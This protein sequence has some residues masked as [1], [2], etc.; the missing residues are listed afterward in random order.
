M[1]IPDGPLAKSGHAGGPPAK[2]LKE[3]EKGLAAMQVDK[4]NEAQQHLKKAQELAPKNP[5]VNYLVGVLYMRRGKS[6]EARDYL[7][8]SRGCGAESRVGFARAGRSRDDSNGITQR[9]QRR[10]ERGVQ[11][12]P[13]AWRAQYLAGVASYQIRDY[14]KALEEAKAALLHPVRI[15][16]ADRCCWWVRRKQRCINEMRRWRRSIN[17]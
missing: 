12:Q 13:T 3:M 1:M 15:R 9:R 11:L 5:D 6:A 16:P 10:L 2:A 4:L 17:I 8:K 7:Q 14:D